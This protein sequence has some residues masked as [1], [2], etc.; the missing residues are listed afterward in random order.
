[1]DISK[2]LDVLNEALKDRDLTIW[3]QK[4][5]IKDLEAE[6]AKLKEKKDWQY[7]KRVENECVGCTYIGLSCMGN[8]CPNRNVVHYYCDKCGEA[9]EVLYYF[10]DEELCISCIIEQLDRVED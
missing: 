2:V 7:M 5:K 4:E 10:E 9:I 1:M 8:S 6:I 3:L